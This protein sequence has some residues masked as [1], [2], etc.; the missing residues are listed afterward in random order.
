MLRRG[1]ILSA[2]IVS[3]HSANT[4]HNELDK[5]NKDSDV[6]PFFRDT[7][8]VKDEY[9]Y[10]NVIVL[11]KSVDCHI[12][13]IDQTSVTEPLKLLIPYCGVDIEEIMK[14]IIITSEIDPARIN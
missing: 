6:N 12:T 13:C 10:S 5:I 1:N 9:R 8:Q 14:K 7:Y 2:S 3:L 4:V 11:V